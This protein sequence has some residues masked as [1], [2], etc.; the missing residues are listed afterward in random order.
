MHVQSIK[1]CPIFHVN[2]RM[3]PKDFGPN[4]NISPYYLQHLKFPYLPIPYLKFFSFSCLKCQH[5]K[6]LTLLGDLN[7]EFKK[8]DVYK[9]LK[10]ET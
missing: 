7:L 8:L 1:G 5:L 6:L 9:H 2:S 4:G 3:L 10:S